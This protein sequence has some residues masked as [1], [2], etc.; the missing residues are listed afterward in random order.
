MAKINVA[1]TRLHNQL[2]TRHP[3]KHPDE[4][5]SYMG[6]MQAQDFA[7]ALWAI[8][9][10]MPKTTQTLIE[11][12]FN[13]GHILRTHVMRPTWHFVAPADIR[14]LQKLTG[15]RVHV[16]NG[17]MYRQN[18]LD[19]KVFSHTRTILE[20]ALRDHNYLT[21]NQLRA[22]F[23][24]AGVDAVGVRLAYIIMHAE[25]ES[26]IC[27]GPRHGKQFTY[28]LLDERA[29]QKGK[30]IKGEE[31]LAELAARYFTSRGP[32]SIQDFSWWSGLPLAQAR[33]GI[34]SIKSSFVSEEI[35]G[36]T[37]WF[38]PS[39][40][41]IR[42]VPTNVFLMPTYDEMGIAYKD[43]SDSLSPET[44]FTW[45]PLENEIFSL[46]LINGFREG[47]W[48]RTLMKGQVNIQTTLFRK[49]TISE[50]RALEKAANDYAKFLGLDLKFA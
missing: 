24:E 16:V 49:F 50:K 20:T 46:I 12:G 29:P 26:V 15:P 17:H 6:A 33:A 28:G 8:G 11:K 22:A 38:T 18:E 47:L 13:E 2:L 32:A 14:W 35:R 21:R 36:Q 7:G 3:Y 48:K 37:Y 1:R 10:R 42:K 27:S 30:V 34:A 40:L 4:V 41:R 39:S 19:A 45:A 9:R 5:V 25:L 23:K 43:R 31:A 44:A